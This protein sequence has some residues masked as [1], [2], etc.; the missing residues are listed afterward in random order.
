MHF[1]AKM[2]AAGEIAAMRVSSSIDDVLFRSVISSES[3]DYSVENQIGR[4]QA[5]ARFHIDVER[6]R[7]A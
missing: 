2:A 1:D 7:Q 3:E 6:R 4:W 5:L